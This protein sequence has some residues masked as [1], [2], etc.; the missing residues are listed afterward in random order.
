LLV[1]AGFI[2]ILTMMLL[3]LPILYCVDMSKGRV[4]AEAYQDGPG[5]GG[6]V[7]QAVSGVEDEED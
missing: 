2:L 6:G 5:D 4:D 1:A 7:A 3:S